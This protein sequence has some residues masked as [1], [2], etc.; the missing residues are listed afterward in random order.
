MSQMHLRQPALEKPAM[1]EAFLTEL[2]NIGSWWLEHT[3]DNEW[4]GFYGEVAADNTPVR[5][6]DKGVVMHSR[7]LWFFSEAALFTGRDEY[8]AA[9]ERAYGYLQRHFYDAEHGGYFW[10]L[11][12]QGKPNSS[13]K[14]VYAQGFVIYGLCAYYQLTQDDS[15]LQAAL[16]CFA[17]IEKHCVDREREGYYEAYT[18]EW[19]RID[20]VR[21]SEKDLNYPKTMNTHLHIVEGYTSLYKVSANKQVGAALS[22]GIDL[23]ERYM[24]DRDSGHLRMFMGDD[25]QDHSSELTYG[26][27]IETA[28]L[29]H[30]ALLAL[31]DKMRLQQ[32]L[33]VI[34]QLAEVCQREAIDDKGGVMDGMHK[35]SSAQHTQRM[36]WVQAEALVGFLTVYKLTGEERYWHTAQNIWGFINEYQLDHEYGE[37][38]WHSSLDEPDSDRD[39]KVGFWKGPYHNGRAMIEA[40]RLLA[41]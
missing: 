5:T 9:A 14:Q 7:I 37:W 1:R 27:D 19:G 33:P 31:D 3:L 17:L 39:Y 21:L 26:H 23:F 28:W 15:A 30:K 38:L 24:I 8:R 32:L 2:E 20:D 6:A 36:W 34:M 12:Y 11:D 16:N 18:R 29:L 22:Y 40:A 10:S 4:G 13:K 25:W 35:L 41:V